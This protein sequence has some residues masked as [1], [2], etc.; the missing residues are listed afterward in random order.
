MLKSLEPTADSGKLLPRPKEAPKMSTLHREFALLK[1]GKAVKSM[2]AV[3]VASEPRQT[4]IACL[5][6]FCFE[7]LLNNRVPAIIHFISGQRLLMQWREREMLEKGRPPTSVELED[8][9]C[10]AFNHLDLQISTISD[11]RSLKF[12]VDFLEEGA[13]AVKLMPETFNDLIEA[14]RY[15][16]LIMGISHHFLATTWEATNTAGL[17]REFLLKSPGGIPVATG[18]N[19][20]STTNIVPVMLPAKQQ[21]YAND[22]SRW[23]RAFAPH[24]RNTRLPTVAGERE[25]H[26]ATLMQIH[27]IATKISLA[28]V[29]FTEECSYDSFLPQFREMLDLIHIIVDA[30]QKRGGETSPGDNTFSLDLGIIPPLFLLLIRCRDRVLRRHTIAILK[31]WHAELCWHPR[32]IAEIGTFLLEVE[33][34]GHPEGPIPETSRAVVTRI[35][36]DPGQIDNNAALLQLLQR[37]GGLNGEPVWK[38]KLVTFANA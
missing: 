35:C 25:F 11:Q 22:I 15:L 36:E 16:V 1:Y 12:H 19:I 30:Y 2:R 6:I 37:R 33:E 18:F 17:S 29:L 8:D 31:I 26:M 38:E 7:M 14:R 20:F 34:E 27:G 21:R 3:L 13:K 32:L 28:G 10:E 4:L 23:F 5:L 24:S 9:L